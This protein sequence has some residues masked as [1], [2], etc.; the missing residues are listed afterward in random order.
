MGKRPG[1]VAKRKNRE[2]FICRWTLKRFAVVDAAVD[3]FVAEG[4]VDALR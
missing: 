1:R 3:Y 2:N 4:F